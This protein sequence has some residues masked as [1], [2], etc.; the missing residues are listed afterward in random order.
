MIFGDKKTFAIE[1]YLIQENGY[2]FVTYCFW[3]KGCK[4]GDL[5]EIAVINSIKY[6]IECVFLFKGKRPNNYCKTNNCCKAEYIKLTEDL[7]SQYH[8]AREDFP[9]D[10]GS[11][12]DECLQGYYIFLLEDNGFDLI[13]VKDAV[14]DKFIHAL[15]PKNHVYKCF[16]KLKTWI[17]DSTVLVLREYLENLEKQCEKIPKQLT[18][19]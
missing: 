2:V 3:I 9:Q 13:L 7:I 14:D 18:L 10:L 12:Q 4:V 5:S 6:L 8:E 17:N 1:V 19:G 16:D 15:I 11:L